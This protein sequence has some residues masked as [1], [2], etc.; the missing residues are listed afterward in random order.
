MW[1]ALT[2]PRFNKNRDTG[3][4]K[5]NLKIGVLKCYLQCLF[6]IETYLSSFQFIMLAF[7]CFLETSQ[8]R[9]VWY[10][11]R[12]SACQ[13]QPVRWPHHGSP[14]VSSLGSGGVDDIM[15]MPIVK[16]YLF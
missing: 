2:H 5:S 3:N 4:L 10:T 14:Q 16:C 13:P 6:L 1:S 8:N 11:L 15:L 12:N 9:D 7:H